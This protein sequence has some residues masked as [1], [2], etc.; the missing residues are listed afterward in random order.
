MSDIKAFVDRGL[1]LTA[2]IARL[3]KELKQIEGKLTEIGLDR[4]Q[5][6]LKDEERE[7]RRWMAPGTALIVPVVFTAD[8]LMGSFKKDSAAH[9]TIRNLAGENFGEFWKFSQKYENRF[10]DG[11]KF[12]KHADEILGAKAPA[13]ITACVAR[14]KLG[15]AKSDV[16]VLWTEPEP[17]VEAKA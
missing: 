11:K 1:Q 16:K 3:E 10:D 15:V 6:F 2:Q 8:K 12:R 4:Q 13:F 7:G 17:V 9:S 5:E 14:D